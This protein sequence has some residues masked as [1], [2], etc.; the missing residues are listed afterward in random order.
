MKNTKMCNA[1]WVLGHEDSYIWTKKPH[2]SALKEERRYFFNSAMT[3]LL[4]VDKQGARVFRLLTVDRSLSTVDRS[5]LTVDR[6]LLTV[7][8]QW[9]RI[10]RL[11]TVDR[12]CWQLTSTERVYFVCWQLKAVYWKLTSNER[13]RVYLVG[14]QLTAVCW[15]LT[16]N[17]RVCISFVDSWQDFI[18][19][20]SVFKQWTHVFRLFL[21][22]V[23][24]LCLAEPRPSAAAGL[25]V[26]EW[27]LGRAGGVLA[28]STQRPGAVECLGRAATKLHHLVHHYL[29]ISLSS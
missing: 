9:G 4:T 5:L 3:Q 24:L 13:V 29:F 2:I 7:D 14:W 27:S 22:L 17:E 28:E 20:Q 23:E 10:F 19:M 11:L 1:S 16:S 12:S 8:K 26:C 15:Q 25:G 21:F 18:Y 6:S